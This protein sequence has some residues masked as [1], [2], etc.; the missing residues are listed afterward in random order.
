MKNQHAS[1]LRQIVVKHLREERFDAV[2]SIGM[3]E[4]VG[5]RKVDEYA[6]RIAAVLESG[7]RVLN[8]G[9]AYVP[10]KRGG[11]HVGGDFS[12]RPQADRSVYAAP[13]AARA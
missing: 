8:H 9:I 4:H 3:V 13:R 7:G 10:H 2:A 12:S 1:P 5:E 6:A 11:V